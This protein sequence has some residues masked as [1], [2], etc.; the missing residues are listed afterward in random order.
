MGFDNPQ[1]EPTPQAKKSRLT[2]NK[3]TRPPTA[4]LPV[5]V[6]C[7]ESFNA[8]AQR[9]KGFAFPK[10]YSS[11]FRV[12]ESEWKELFSSPLI[13]SAAKDKLTSAGAMD[14]KGKYI[15]K[16]RRT[17]ESELLRI[18][19]AARMRLKFSSSLLLFAEV[20]MLAFQQR[21]ERLIS[22]RD[23]GILINMIR[24]VC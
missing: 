22:R 15:S 21:E 2:L 1:D 23:T 18:D 14:P 12:D 6:E 5:D 10:K 9:R 8:I 4:S 13:P 3:P 16:D 11:T 17:L 20:I 24:T 19:S 7:S